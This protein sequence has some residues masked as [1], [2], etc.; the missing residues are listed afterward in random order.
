EALSVL[1]DLKLVI[2]RPDT[3]SAWE[4]GALLTGAVI[5]TSMGYAK[6][7]S[8]PGCSEPKHGLLT[9]REVPNSV[10]KTSKISLEEKVIKT[11]G[12]FSI[13]AKFRQIVKDG[14]LFVV[15]ECQGAK[16]STDQTRAIGAMI[17]H[18]VESGSRSKALLLSGSP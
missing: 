13:T 6:L 2:I 11:H 16:N 8:T 1:L 3:V 7:R 4:A 9:R 10:S 12:E 14:V 18:I 5:H 17:N 15:D